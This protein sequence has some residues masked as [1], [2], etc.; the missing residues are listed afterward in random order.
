[1]MR[2]LGWLYIDTWIR[3][4]WLSKLA[5]AAKYTRLNLY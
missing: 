5:K 1:M 4:V 3:E 2:F